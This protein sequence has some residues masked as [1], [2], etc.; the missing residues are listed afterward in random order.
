MI[1]INNASRD[2]RGHVMF[3]VKRDLEEGFRFVGERRFLNG[4]SA[5]QTVRFL[6]VRYRLAAVRIALLHPLRLAS[7]RLLKG[8]RRRQILGSVLLQTLLKRGHRFRVAFQ[9]RR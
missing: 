5:A 9:P 1:Y 8:R 3:I 7:F 4:V 2:I 6:D